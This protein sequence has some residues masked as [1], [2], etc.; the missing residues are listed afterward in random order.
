MSPWTQSWTSSGLPGAG[1]YMRAPA[2]LVVDRLE[3]A[4]LALDQIELGDEAE[5]LG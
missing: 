1:R 3:R 5:P 4:V 2:A